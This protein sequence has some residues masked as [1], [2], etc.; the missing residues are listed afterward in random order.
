MRIFIA[1]GTLLLLAP[2]CRDGKKEPVTSENHLDA[3]RNFIRAA[4][5]GKF[6]DA[7]RF[8]LADSTNSNWMDVAERNYNKSDET[9]R[10]GYRTASINVHRADLLNDSV[11]IVVYSNSF[12]NDHDTLKVVRTTGQWL[13]DLK[14]LYLHEAESAAPIPTPNDTLK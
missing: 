14:Y 11:A 1:I 10:N 12:K 4:L 13:V 6:K 2:A 5:D 9:T 7:R 8:M 3:A